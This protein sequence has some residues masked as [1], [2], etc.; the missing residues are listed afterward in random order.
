MHQKLA[1]DPFLILLINPKQPLHTRNLKISYSERGL[2]KTLKKIKFIFFFLNPVPF[3][4][5]IYQ[6]QKGSGT[7]HQSIF[8][9]GNKLR[10]ISLF[11]IYYQTKFDDF[12]HSTSICP[13]ESGKWEVRKKITKC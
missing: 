11:I 1:P 9:S 13:F 7:S 8:K 6:K 4:R 5:Q 12:I 10:K 3:N 2:P